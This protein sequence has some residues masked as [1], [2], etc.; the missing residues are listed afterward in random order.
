MF[1]DVPRGPGAVRIKIC[2]ICN[3]E[4]AQAAIDLGADAIGL[5]GYSGSK[6]YLDISAAG[7][8]LASLPSQIRKVAVLVNPTLEHALRIAALPFIDSLQLHGSEAPEFCRELAGQGVPFAKALP[9]VDAYSLADVQSFHT[10]WIVLDSA[11]A[12]V[13]GGSGTRF[14]WQ[15]ARDLTESQTHL[16]VVLAGGL[17]PDNVAEAIRVVR[18]FGVDVTTG[19]ESSPGRK[20]HARLRAFIDAAREAS[21][22][23]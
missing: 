19:V 4:D 11:K 23:V 22:S 18:P 17:M 3:L 9:V 7:D 2:G 10:N 16:N 5:N 20:D 14:D 12:G 8:W 6:R 1:H 15:L 21:T 13:F